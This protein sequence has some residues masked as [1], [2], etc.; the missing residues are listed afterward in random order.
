MK[1]HRW[2]LNTP[3]QKVRNMS[4]N[5]LLVVDAFRRAFALATE[6]GVNVKVVP[7]TVPPPK[8]PY[9]VRMEIMSFEDVG[10]Y[11]N[12]TDENRSTNHVS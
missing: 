2:P 10:S 3:P 6:L 1:I 5:R 11:L 12:Q 8:H 4:D 7:P 9:V